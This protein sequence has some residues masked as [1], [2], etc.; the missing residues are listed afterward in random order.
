[1]WPNH[2]PNQPTIALSLQGLLWSLCC[3]HKRLNTSRALPTARILE[4]FLTPFLSSSYSDMFVSL[5]QIEFYH[6]PPCSQFQSSV[7]STRRQQSSTLSVTEPV[8]HSLPAG[9][10][11]VPESHTLGFPDNRSEPSFQSHDGLSASI[12]EPCNLFNAELANIGH[13]TEG[14]QLQ[15]TGPVEGNGSS[16]PNGEVSHDQE[17]QVDE[18]GSSSSGK[19]S[20]VCAYCT[21]WQWL[22]PEPCCNPEPRHLGAAI[23][24]SAVIETSL[25]LARS[26]SCLSAQ[27]NPED[28]VASVFPQVDHKLEQVLC[29]AQNHDQM[30]KS[31]CMYGLSSALLLTVLSDAVHIDEGCASRASSMPCRTLAREEC[32]TSYDWAMGDSRRPD[33]LPLFSLESSPVI[34]SSCQDERQDGSQEK[35]SRRRW[36]DNR[37]KNQGSGGNE[38]DP[39]PS[40]QVTTRSGWRCHTSPEEPGADTLKRNPSIAV[41]IPA[42]AWMRMRVTRSTTRARARKRKLQHDQTS[43]SD[44]YAAG[45][46]IEPAEWFDEKWQCWKKKHSCAVRPASAGSHTSMQPD[47]S[48]QNQN[49]LGRAI[50]TVQ[51]DGPKPAYLFTF[52]LEPGQ[53][54]SSQDPHHHCEKHGWLKLFGPPA[55]ISGKSQLYSSEENAL[56]TRLKEWEGMSWLEIAQHTSLVETCHHFKRIIQVNYEIRQSLVRENHEDNESRSLGSICFTC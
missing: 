26:P 49:I 54:L 40:S 1:M 34:E 30:G 7:S 29:P 19:L 15:N 25:D 3:S 45:P 17:P 47:C 44:H 6:G 35:T 16:C 11:L 2:R 10:V 24:K 42:P 31:W 52:M 13:E 41:V 20:H 23:D 8:H 56:L 21:N 55:N 36:A 4:L 12:G 5:N 9:P 50:L 27:A 32:S 38:R 22:F 39:P 28:S 46:S 48:P 43:D 33:R 51:S 14:P 53:I 37:E 18:Y